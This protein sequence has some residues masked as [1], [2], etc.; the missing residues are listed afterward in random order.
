MRSKVVS[1][2]TLILIVVISVAS[3]LLIQNIFFNKKQIIKETVKNININETT[4]ISSAVNKV[5]DSV[6]YI[7]KTSSNGVKNSGSG[8]IYK[9]DK[10]YAYI[11]TNNHVIQDNVSLK[12]INSQ[13]KS[14]NAT[15]VGAD[16]YS[17]LA[18]IKIVNDGV[19]SVVE[20]GSSSSSLV[21]DTVFAIGSPV[22]FEYMNSITKGTIS[23]KNRT[24][25]ITRSTGK[26]LLEVIQVDAAINPGN[27]GGPLCD[28]NG[29]VIG[30]TSLKLIE[31]EV[32]GMGFAIPIETAM[33]IIDEL[34]KGNKIIRPYLGITLASISDT[35]QLYNNDI[36]VDKNIDKGAVITKVEN[37]SV[38][39]IAGLARKDVII[40]IDGKEV[41]SAAHFN[42]L[43]YKHKKGDKIRLKYVRN[44]ATKE[45]EILI[46]AMK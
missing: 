39:A 36:F 44:G 28:L 34:E 2:T 27:S 6:V 14:Y 46:S 9:T 5:Y 40:E 1:L 22:G 8:F 38:A 17:D 10:S 30:V 45:V 18:V 32:E 20:I 35:W 4:T 41:D 43:L 3:T 19:L 7:E 12:V 11:I 24:V 13:G 26:E 29:T 25:A 21:G 33:L 37:N 23:G 15:I 42:Y 16:E 31:T